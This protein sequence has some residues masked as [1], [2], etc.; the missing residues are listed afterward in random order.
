MQVLPKKSGEA[1]QPDDPFEKSKYEFPKKSG[2]LNDPVV[3]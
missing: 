3:P 1:I 2:E